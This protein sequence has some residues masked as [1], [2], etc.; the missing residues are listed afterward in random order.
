MNIVATIKKKLR[1][2]KEQ[3]RNIRFLDEIVQFHSIK[4]I[5]N[6]NALHS[7]QSLT[8]K[9]Q[10]HSAPLVV[11]LTTYSVRIHS[12]HLVIESIAQQTVKPN[13]IVLW[14]DENEFSLETIPFI[15]KR[16]IDRG[17]EVRFCP[18]YRSYKK[19]YPTIDEFPGYDIITLDDDFIYPHD[20]IEQL[21][22][23][24]KHHPNSIIGHRTHKILIKNKS[25]CPYNE[26]PKETNDNSEPALNF[27][28]TGAG[29]LFTHEIAQKIFVTNQS[30]MDTCPSSDDVWVNINAIL[31]NID[32]I[33]VDDPRSFRKRFIHINDELAIG[34][35][36]QNTGLNGGND[37][38]LKKL[39]GDAYHN[40]PYGAE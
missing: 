35:N 8:T 22:T 39:L 36:L 20:T 7:T 3:I 23:T 4:H 38:Q 34:L 33:K 18:N 30:F 25:I 19:I 11:S 27:V 29:T 24:F 26:W 17:L 37:Q 2:K 28:T 16:Q 32:R 6:E 31:H 13:R 21:I 9:E 14:L 10:Y 12:I 40:F 1:K 15:L 5:I